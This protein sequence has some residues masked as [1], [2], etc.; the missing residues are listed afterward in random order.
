L[1]AGEEEGFDAGTYLGLVSLSKRLERAEMLSNGGDAYSLLGQGPLGRQ[2]HATTP[3][4][5]VH[6]PP[7]L[8]AARS[9]VDQR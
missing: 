3:R 7:S 9:G 5:E 1:G 4:H 6:P 8:G 2:G